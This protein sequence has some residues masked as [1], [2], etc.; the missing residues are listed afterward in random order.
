SWLVG[1]RGRLRRGRLRW[2]PSRRGRLRWGRLRWGGLR[3]GSV[4]SRVPAERRHGPLLGADRH[5]RP[6]L[7]QAADDDP[8]IGLQPLG[9]HAQA[10][11][12]E[13]GRGDSA[14]LDLVVLVNHVDE[15]DSLVRAD[16]LVDHQYGG[17]GLADWQ[18]N[19]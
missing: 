17:M 4:G 14:V 7:L 5:T 13:R 11:V 18:A 3:R 9:D 12:L 2:N 19:S 15:L 6:D 16:R 8:F 1:D 10:I